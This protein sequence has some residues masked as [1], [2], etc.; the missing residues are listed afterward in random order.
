MASTNSIVLL[1]LGTMMVTTVVGARRSNMFQYLDYYPYELEE[2]WFDLQ[3]DPYIIVGGKR[4]ILA[5]PPPI[6]DL[7]EDLYDLDFFY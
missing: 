7:E 5:R 4:I 6:F 3:S 1:L 2:E